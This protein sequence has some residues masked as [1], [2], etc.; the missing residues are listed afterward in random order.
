MNSLRFVGLAAMRDR[1]RPAG[2]VGKSAS[3]GEQV[4]QPTVA[5]DGIYTR[6]PHL[7]H[8]SNRLGG[9]LVHEDCDVRIFNET[10]I[11]EPLLDESLSLFQAEATD[12]NVINQR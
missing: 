7:P 9:V 8:H 1:K 6:F 4:K 3:C 10:A 11:I 12:M 2:L 5:Q